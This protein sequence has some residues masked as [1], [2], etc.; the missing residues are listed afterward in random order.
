[1]YERNILHRAKRSEANWIGHIWRRNCLLHHDVEGKIMG[2]IEVTGRR[3]RRSKHLLDD[4]KE[5]GEYWESME[6]ALVGP[7]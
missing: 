2:R 1:V 3:G 7:L 5:T 4:F 6:E